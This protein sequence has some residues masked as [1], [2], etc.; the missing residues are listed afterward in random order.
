MLALFVL[1]V[2]YISI[3]YT[4][5]HFPFILE[6][7]SIKNMCFPEFAFTC[8]LRR[9]VNISS[10]ILYSGIQAQTCTCRVIDNA[11]KMPLCLTPPIPPTVISYTA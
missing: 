1:S 8:S 2:R 10:T 7:F 5:L 4:F 3:Y 11:M 9:R 6:Y